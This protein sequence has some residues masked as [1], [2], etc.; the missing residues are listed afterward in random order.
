VLSSWFSWQPPLWCKPGDSCRQRRGSA[1]QSR[2]ASGE[3]EARMASS[4]ASG[5]SFVGERKKLCASTARV[6]AE[7]EANR[8][9]YA[10]CCPSVNHAKLHFCLAGGA[11]ATRPH[12]QLELGQRYQPTPRHQPQTRQRRP[13][14]HARAAACGAQVAAKCCALSNHEPGIRLPLQAAADR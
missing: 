3:R 13:K 2:G 4:T 12:C 8:R 10:C 7:Y 14:A 11:T 5:S 9:V 1:G 6:S